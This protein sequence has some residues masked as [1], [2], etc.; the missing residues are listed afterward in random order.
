MPRR[1]GEVR[2]ALD[3]SGAGTDDADA[4]S[5]QVLQLFAGVA[6][7]PA[8]GMERLPEEGPDPGDAGELGFGLI[9][10][11]HGDEL[12]PHLVPVVGADE[13][14]GSFGLPTDLVDV[15]LEAGIVVQVVALGNG[16]AVGKDLGA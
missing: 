5:G 3:R 14:P 4:L 15:G 9:P 6:V 8:T 1:R 2:D 10:V 16:P 12:G 13:P 11:G 7:V